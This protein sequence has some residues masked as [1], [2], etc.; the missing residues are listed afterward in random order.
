MTGQNPVPGTG[1]INAVP[2][3]VDPLN[4]TKK[5]YG[6]KPGS[7]AKNTADPTVTVTTDFDGNTRPQDGRSDMG[8]DEVMPAQ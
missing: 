4:A 5:N 3:F 7:P 8:A 2:M 1:N 6:L